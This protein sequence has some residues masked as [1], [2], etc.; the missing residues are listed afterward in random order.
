MGKKIEVGVIG[1]GHLGKLHIKNLKEIE[2]E[3]NDVSVIGTYDIDLNKSKL[4][5]TELNAKAFDTLDTLLENINTAIIVTPTSTHFEIAN[6]IITQ[7]INVFI[8]KPVTDDINDA[9]KLL[10][11]SKGK[12]IKIQ[13]GHIE[14]FNPAILS[15]EQYNLAPLFIETHRLAQ[16]N[17]RGTDVSVIQDLM[18]H[19]ID[20]ILNLVK[21]NVKTINA[22]GASIIT[23]K[24]DIA[25]V[26]IKFDNGCVANITSS[27]ISQH[28]MRK[29]R[30][31]QH[32]AYISIDFS[33]NSSEVF[34]LVEKEK[35]KSKSLE[36]MFSLGTIKRGGKELQIVYEQPKIEESNPMK[37]E[38]NKFFNCIRKGSE[39]E[40]QLKD[41]IQALEVATKINEEVE[42]S[43]KE[44]K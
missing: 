10:K 2:K 9:K 43:L 7:D 37:Y 8:E 24:I 15:L 17:P 22:N 1:C 21:S 5:S 13:I 39:P 28:K 18:I 6:K 3:S 41:G 34:R 20:I 42:M 38:Q 40:V 12:D 4:A 16:F 32:N 23:D 11:Q 14:R 26:R 31:F 29:M 19:D 44:I 30:I 35:D 33:Q 36:P 27:R 25:N